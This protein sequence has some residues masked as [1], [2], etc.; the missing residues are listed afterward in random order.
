MPNFARL[1]DTLMDRTVAPGYTRLGPA[2][3]RHLST[4]PDDPPA[5]ALSGKRPW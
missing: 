4:W 5:D 2:V 1:V 3:R